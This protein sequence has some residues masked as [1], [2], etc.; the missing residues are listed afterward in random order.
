MRNI[1]LFLLLAICSCTYAQTESFPES[2]QGNWKGTLSWYR[3]G[4]DSAM[5]VNMELHI[6][7]TDSADVWNWQLIYGSADKDDRPYRL[8]KKDDKGIHWVIDELNGIILDQ[9]WVNGKFCGAFTVMNSTII[10][11]YWMEG[12]NLIVEFYSI[13]AKPVNTTGKGDEEV[14]YVQSYAVSS[15]QKAVLSRVK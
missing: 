11:S 5:K 6:S 15:Y 7:S 2:W 13:G 12:E 9:Y 1:F 14:P 8:I 4:S 10:N 3:T